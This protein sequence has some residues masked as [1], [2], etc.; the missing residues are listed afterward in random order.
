MPP[1][2]AAARGGEVDDAERPT[3]QGGHRRT[4]GA[5]LTAEPHRARPWSSR[6]AS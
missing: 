3:E 2:A 5:V 6:L 1:R 4:A